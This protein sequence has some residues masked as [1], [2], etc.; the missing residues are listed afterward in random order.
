MK[1]TSIM[2]APFGFGEELPYKTF[3][4]STL[5]GENKKGWLVIM[6]VDVEQRARE[7]E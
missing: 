5:D 4:I 7:K 1:E 3:V 6:G 2:L